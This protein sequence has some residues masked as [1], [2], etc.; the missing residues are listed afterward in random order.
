MNLNYFIQSRN[1]KGYS[2]T[3]LAKELGVSTAII[4]HWEKGLKNPKVSVLIELCRILDMDANKLL[5]LN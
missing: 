3:M 1:S 4:C 5:N 2:K